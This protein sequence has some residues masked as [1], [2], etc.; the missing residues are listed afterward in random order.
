MRPRLCAVPEELIKICP[1]CGCK[2]KIVPQKNYG[3][4]VYWEK[5]PIE[6][7]NRARIAHQG[8]ALVCDTSCTMAEVLDPDFG[9]G[10]DVPKTEL[11]GV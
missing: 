7:V 6:A 8:T 3:V 2:G 1:R 4:T 11:K 10:Y 9:C 5:S